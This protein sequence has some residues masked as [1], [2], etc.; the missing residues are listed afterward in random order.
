MAKRHLLATAK[1]SGTKLVEA[2]EGAPVVEDNITTKLLPYE[3]AY[4]ALL[5]VVSDRLSKLQV[6]IIQSQKLEIAL[7]DIVEW[8]T[9]VEKRQDKQEIPVLRTEKI[10]DLQMEQDVSHNTLSSIL[11]HRFFRFNTFIEDH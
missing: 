4:D 9:E 3:E 5:A 8:L 1:N 11:T 10:N 7:A 2:S 6:M